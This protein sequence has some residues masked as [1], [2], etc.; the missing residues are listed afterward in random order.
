MACHR[1]QPRSF[2]YVRNSVGK[3]KMEISEELSKNFR[4]GKYDQA[5]EQL[6]QPSVYVNVN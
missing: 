2:V 6:R 5:T 4:E 3:N 1:Q